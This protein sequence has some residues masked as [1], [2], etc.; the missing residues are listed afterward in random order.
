MSDLNHRERVLLALD[1]T[2][3]D[4]VP[5]AMVCAGINPPARAA[6]EERLQAERGIGVDDYLKPILD[7]ATV[8]PRNVG[9]ALEPGTDVWG[10]LRKPVS[11]GSGSDNE[12]DH[13]PLAGADLDAVA[14]HRWPQ[15]E[16]FDYTAVAEEIA[17]ARADEPTACGV[18]ATAV[19]LVA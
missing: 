6:L 3:T 9:P 15:T 8:A 5:I 10:V 12:I 1:H 7:I 2:E 13:Y 17:R 4:R 19:R 16:W 14:R 18:A 11:Y